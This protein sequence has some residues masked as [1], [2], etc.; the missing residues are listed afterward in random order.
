MRRF[1]CESGGVKR[2]NES[3][4][5]LCC[6]FAPWCC[7][8]G[9][10]WLQNTPSSTAPQ[11]KRQ[12]YPPHCRTASIQASHQDTAALFA[13]SVIQSAVVFSFFGLLYL[14]LSI[15]SPPRFIRRL[16]PRPRRDRGMTQT[17]ERSSSHYPEDYSDSPPCVEEEL[18]GKTFKHAKVRV[19]QNP[20]PELKPC[21]K[22]VWNNNE[23]R[24]GAVQWARRENGNRQGERIRI[25]LVEAVCCW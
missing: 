7:L 19:Q 5:L 21:W 23:Y 4:L 2:F 12:T 15:S 11:L 14:H 17:Q 25:L 24:F 3:S 20:L 1:L 6:G 18:Q 10:F 22:G 13:L 8:F 9:A 16:S